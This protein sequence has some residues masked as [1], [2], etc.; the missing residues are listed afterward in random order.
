MKRGGGK[1][2]GNRY[3]N[4]VGRT[5]SLWLTAGKDTTQLIPS[6]LSGGWQDRQARHAGDLAPNGKIGDRFRKVFVVECKHRKTDLLRDIYKTKGENI[7]GWWE[8]LSDEAGELDLVP[9]LICRQNNRP[10]LVGLPIP[11][12]WQV[13]EWTHSG[14]LECPWEQVGLILLSALTTIKPSVL[15]KLIP[16]PGEE[17]RA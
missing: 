17:W 6:R 9:L 16:R 11:L 3:E 1:G 4:H 13:A 2:K 14:M 12:A 7:Q 5:L 15:Y 10:D 8:K